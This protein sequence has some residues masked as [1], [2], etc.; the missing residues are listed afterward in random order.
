MALTLVIEDSDL[1]AFKKLC[2]KGMNTWDDAPPCIW[3]FDF[4]LTSRIEV[5]DRAFEPNEILSQ[6]PFVAVESSKITYEA[7]DG[8]KTAGP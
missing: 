7:D 1:I 2:N 6:L 5:L 4:A 8:S 3:R